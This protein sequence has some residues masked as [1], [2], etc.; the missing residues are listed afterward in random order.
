MSHVS[1]MQVK[2]TDVDA[3]KAACKRMNAQFC[4]KGFVTFY[5]ETEVGGIVIQLPGWQYSIVVKPDGSIRYDNYNGEWGDI[6]ELNL[7]KQLYAIETAKQ[8]AEEKGY[9]YQEDELPNGVLKLTI[10]I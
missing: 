7:F 9:T 4:G 6:K 10:Q 5:D 2:I 3:M 8:K 1:Q